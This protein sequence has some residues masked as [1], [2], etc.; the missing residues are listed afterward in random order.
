MPFYDD[1]LIRFE[2]EGAPELPEAYQE[3][4]VQNREANIWYALYGDGLPVVLLHGGLGH[5]GSW[6]GQVPALITSGY[7]VILSRFMDRHRYWLSTA[8]MMNSSN[9]NMQNIW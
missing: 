5:R 1:N 2:S 7:Q 4:Y 6:G 3:G 8:K 9:R